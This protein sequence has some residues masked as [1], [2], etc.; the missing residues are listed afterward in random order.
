MPIPL[1]TAEKRAIS[2]LARTEWRVTHAQRALD[3]ALAVRAYLGEKSVEELELPRVSKF[4]WPLQPANQE[5]N[6]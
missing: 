4:G 2:L 1:T 6:K 3:H 5:N